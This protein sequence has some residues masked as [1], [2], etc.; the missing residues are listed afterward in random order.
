MKVD[1]ILQ[2][3]NLKY[4]DLTTA[5]KDTLHSWMDAL[6]KSKVTLEMVK[7]H[8]E[9]MRDSVETELTQVGHN[10]KQDIFLKARLRNYMLL[11]AFLHSPEK[12]QQAL[13]RALAGLVNRK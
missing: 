11:Q 7:T 3:V 1:D 10:S 5:E 13:D 6:T 2:R 8:I 12:A 4:E 9:A